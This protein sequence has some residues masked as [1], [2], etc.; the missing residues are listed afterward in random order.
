MFPYKLERPL[1]VFD[2]EATGTNPRTDRIVE[3]AV[4][5]IFP[6]DRREV[7]A[8][9]VNPGVPIPP[10]ATQVHGITD[11][12]VARCPTFRDLAPRLLA[13]FDGCDLGGY[14]CIRFDVPL[15]IEEFLRVGAQ[16]PMEGRRLIDAQRIF[17]K[18]EPR[19]L[20]AA[21]AFYCKDTHEDAHGAE[22]DALATIRVLEG[23]FERYPDLP[24]TAAELDRYCDLRDPSWAD[25]EGRLRWVNGEI[26]INFGK[27]KGESLRETAKNDPGFLR[28]ILK[29]D[30]PSDTKEIVQKALDNK[31]AAPLGSA[32]SDQLPGLSLP[33]AAPKPAKK[34]GA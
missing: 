33:P 34:P 15:L 18:R 8:F 31:T 32:L 9:R 5:R 22:A 21:L 6:D 10:E 16:F 2:L 7:H 1:A 14:N 19:D 29:G 26:T 24:R 3:V 13:L 25:R 17:H 28:W 27:K 4:V 11:A 12:D 30:F 20:S 23:Q